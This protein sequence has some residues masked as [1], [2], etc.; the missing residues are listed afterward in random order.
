MRAPAAASLVLALPWAAPVW[1]Q[2][3]EALQSC[4]RVADRLE[5]VACYDRLLPPETAATAPAAATVP[6]PAPLVAGDAARGDSRLERYW[7]LHEEAQQGMLVLLPFKQNYA[8]PITYNASPNERPFEGSALTVDELE[9]KYQFSFKLKLWQDMFASPVDLWLGYTQQSY[10]QLFDQKSSPFR[11]TDY[12]PTAFATLPVRFR[13]FGLT[14]RFLAL[15]FVHQSNG[16][17]E[18]F[19]RSWNRIVGAAVFERGNLVGQVRTWYRIPED[20]AED[21]NPDIDDY[22]GFADV[23]LSWTRGRQEWSATLKGNWRFDRNRS[24]I[25]LGWSFPL[26]R[27]SPL[28]GYVQYYYGY[29][30]SLIDYNAK[31]HRAGVGF[32]VSDWF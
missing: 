7:D 1:A 8:L 6:A 9:F 14:T 11:E 23:S 16:R 2:S 30:E 10:W 22:L 21:D 5:R 20:E 32:M 26:W 18:T 13:V 4:R 17:G 28:R 27:E 24:G 31:V 3:D 19:S 12:E 25:E 15:G 29:G